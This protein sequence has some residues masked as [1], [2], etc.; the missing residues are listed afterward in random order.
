MWT[1]GAIVVAAAM[2]CLTIQGGLNILRRDIQ[3]RSKK[4]DEINSSLKT[5]ANGFNEFFRQEFEAQ[6]K[7]RQKE[8][9]A[10]LKRSAADGTL[11]TF[12]S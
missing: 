6:Q 3:A 5:I 12:E 2:I 4:L 10:I 8:I 11:R 7:Q 1:A 9:D